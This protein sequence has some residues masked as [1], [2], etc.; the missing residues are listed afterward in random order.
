MSDP[1]VVPT[2][3]VLLALGLAGL[4]L[5]RGPTL[6]DR[7]VALDLL[8]TLAVGVIA[9]HAVAAGDAVYL[10]AA[11]VLGAVAFI[12]TLAFAHFIDRTGGTR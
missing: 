5:L 3:L 12:G 2:A 11:L 8:S 4:R 9:L 1:F 10:D 7:A 6:A